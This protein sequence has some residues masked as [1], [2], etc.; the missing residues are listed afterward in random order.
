MA[1]VGIQMGERKGGGHVRLSSSASSSPCGETTAAME[2]KR[3]R[4][5]DSPRSLLCLSAMPCS[6]VAPT[7]AWNLFQCAIVNGRKN[8]VQLPCLRVSGEPSDRFPRSRTSVE[9]TRQPWAPP[10]FCEDR[11]L[12][13]SFVETGNLPLTWNAK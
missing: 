4:E 5:R 10:S 3:E 2:K 11:P 9:A 8:T 13:R 1:S 6:P 12:F 7:A